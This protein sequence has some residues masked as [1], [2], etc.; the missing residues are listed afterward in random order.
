M[1]ALWSRFSL[2]A[3][4][5][6][7][8]LATIALAA[9]FAPWLTPFS[10]E[11]QDTLNALA[12]PDA[13]HW[14]GTDRLGR[15]LFSRMLYGARVSL[16]LGIGT[17]LIALIIGTVYGAIS[18]Y[19][20]G[21]TDN[22]LMRVVDVIFALPD[23]LLIILIM[24]VLGRGLT[25]IF[26]ALTMVSW[27]TVARL[28]RGEVLRIKEFTFVEAARA[29][30]AGHRR[31]LF[32]EIVPNLWGILIVTLTFRIPVAILAEST[33]SFIGLGIAPPFSSW[34]T[35]A[36]DGWTAIKFYPHLIVFPS[37]AIFLT[38]LA[39]NFLGEGLRD[40]FDPRKSSI[41]IN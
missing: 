24:V 30:G 37:L 3:K 26:L 9:V 18:G 27:V 25:S 32:S 7:C 34:G 4:L 8:F 12:A 16:F 33:L 2:P 19:I 41:E 14:M 5:S 6:A 36:N 10:Y 15:D 40:Y 13:M 28:V 35:L 20:G 22:F 21:R 38:I 1:R 23:L 31:I 39:F 29:L 17:T 11:E